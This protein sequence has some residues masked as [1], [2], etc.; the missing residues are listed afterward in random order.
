MLHI[1]TILHPT[2][3]SSC[4]E[5]AF[6]V[7]CSLARDHGGR[8]IVMHVKSPP[9]TIMGEFGMPPPT[10]EDDLDEL[11]AQLEHICC[12]EPSVPVE[13][14]LEEGSPALEILAVARDSGC[15]L[16][17]MGTHGHGALHQAVLGSVAEE[18]VRNAPCSVLTVKMPVAET[19]EAQSVATPE[20]DTA[21]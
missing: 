1:R 11:Q 2:D 10:P 4:S 5:N 16:I 18:V 17:V 14:Q 6:H 9:E 12:A 15:D 8:L 13:W 3:F 20:V 21:G 7:A 19:V